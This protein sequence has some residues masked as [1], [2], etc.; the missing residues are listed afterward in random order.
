MK[1]KI[2]VSILV[3]AS[4]IAIGK[5]LTV[6]PSYVS[7]AQEITP[8]E[9]V[10]PAYAKWGKLAMQNVMSKYPTANIIDYLHVGQEKGTTTSVEKFKLWLKEENR[11]FGV[12]VDITFN[13]QTEEVVNIEY[14]ET[15]R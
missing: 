6:P 12:F 9:Q 14:T 5:I 8:A 7:S 1:K 15:D 11:E 10:A 2:V 3:I 13:N 4:T